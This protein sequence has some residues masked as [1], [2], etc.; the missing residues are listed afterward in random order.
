MNKLLNFVLALFLL[1]T[2]LQ[3]STVSA[4][5][6][7]SLDLSLTPI[8]GFGGRIIANVP[9]ACSGTSL[10]TILDFRTLSEI[11]V[12]YIPFLSRLNQFYMLWTPSNFVL[13]T[14][15][16]SSGV[17]SA[18][19]KY[20]SVNGQTIQDDPFGNPSICY[21]GIFPFCTSVGSPVGIITPW[22][23][24]GAGTSL[25]PIGEVI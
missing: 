2:F 24:S 20:L 17:T 7:S 18:F 9:C 14:Y 22:P 15:L 19:T 21:E 16:G 12:V 10:L 3:Y 1:G 25:T 4:A 13:G 6:L 8:S 5:S 23:F 11:Q